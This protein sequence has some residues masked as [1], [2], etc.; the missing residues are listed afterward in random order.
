MIHS[1]LF[2]SPIAWPW[3]IIVAMKPQT[4]AVLCQSPYHWTGA[5]LLSAAVLLGLSFFPQRRTEQQAS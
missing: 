2:G 5:Y 4:P 1:P 3:D